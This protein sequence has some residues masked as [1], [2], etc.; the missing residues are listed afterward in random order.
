MNHINTT[1]VFERNRPKLMG[2]AYRFLG[3]VSDAEDVVQDV[4]VKW[5]QVDHSSIEK[6]EAWLNKV[7]TRRCLDIVKSIEKTRVDYVGTWLP[8]PIFTE[9]DTQDNI[10]SNLELA[11]SLTTAFLLALE[12]LSPKERAAFL[13]HSVF[14]SPYR[15]VAEILDID[16]AACR[17]LVSRAKKHLEQR[18]VRNA[19]P[20]EK[21]DQFLNA[22]KYAIKEGDTSKLQ[23]MLAKDIVIRADG[24]GKVAAILND[25]VG[26]KE[27]LSFLSADLKDYWQGFSWLETRINSNP[28]FV[29]KNNEAIHAVVSFEFDSDNSATEI[30]IVRNP[31][32][33]KFIGAT[34]LN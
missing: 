24:G 9:Q 12:R 25:I 26:L 31:D 6:A 4:Y 17:Q 11:D 28:G 19:V 22:F 30:F 5:S 34:P 8:E 21:V 14:D 33:L 7:C 32:K 15:D 10:L 18:K 2:I 13:L 3:S 27:V 1:D 16:E 23:N 20:T 29:I